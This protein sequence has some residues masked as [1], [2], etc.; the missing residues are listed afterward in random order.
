MLEPAIIAFRLLQYL[1][2]AILL[3]SSLFFV[4]ALP[5]PGPWARRLVA[6]GAVLL[7]V[8]SALAIGAQASLFA[9]SFA[10]GFTVG[11]MR[12]VVAFMDLGKAALARAVVAALAAILI[13]VLPAGRASWLL[14]AALGAAAAASLAW[15]GHG[16]AGEGGLG[17][18][19][20]AGDIL[21]ALAA[22]AWIGAL[23]CFAVLLFQPGRAPVGSLHR[24]LVRFSGFGPAIVALLVVTGLVNAWILV[25]SEHALD[26]WAIPYGRLL[27]AKLVLFLAMLAL[28]G[29]NRFRHTGT[30]LAEPEA[31]SALRLSIAAETA[32]GLAILALVAWLGTLAPPSAA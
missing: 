10:D 22:S 1:G 13:L 16:A 23:V 2:A 20:L 28:A 31:R 7:A 18:I 19:Q 9:G 6:G 11:A 21:H 12:E 26:L 17:K 4:Y 32:A 24:A 29:L 5:G 30:L 8:A 3:G 15:L 27:A 25:G 14:A